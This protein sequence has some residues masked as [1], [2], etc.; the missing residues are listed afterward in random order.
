[1]LICFNCAHVFGRP[2][3]RAYSEKEKKKKPKRDSRAFGQLNTLILDGGVATCH[4]M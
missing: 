2:A 4:V 1:M 3:E